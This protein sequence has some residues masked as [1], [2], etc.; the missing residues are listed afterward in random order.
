MSKVARKP[1]ELPENIKFSI[2]AHNREDFK[3]V[4]GYDDFEKVIENLK[5]IFKYRNKGLQYR[6]YSQSN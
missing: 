3:K 5:W 6:S 2:N 4:H 1:I